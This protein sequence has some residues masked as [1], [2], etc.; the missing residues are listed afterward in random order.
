M[1]RNDRS[2]SVRREFR[3]LLTGGWN[4]I[5]GY[6]S[7]III[8]DTL[9]T[10]LH[11][12]LIALL[13]N[14]ISISVAFVSYKLFVF[15]TKGNWLSEYARSYVVYGGAAILGIGLLWVFVDGIGMPFWLAQ[16]LV[17]V[18]TVVFSF[19]SHSRFTFASAGGSISGDRRTSG[20]SAGFE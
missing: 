17:I 2:V 3:Y 8:Y 20:E 12:A 19:V 13:G 11:I 16:A 7:S 6:V 1:G 4:T 15:R 9:H 5:F 10:R 18:I 14:I